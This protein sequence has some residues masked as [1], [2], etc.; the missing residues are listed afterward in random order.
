M[1]LFPVDPLRLIAAIYRVAPDKQVHVERLVERIFKFERL[2]FVSAHLDA[3]EI[4]ESSF[5]ELW[6]LDIGFY[7]D[8]DTANYVCVD[9]HDSAN[10]LN[11]PLNPI[12][13]NPSWMIQRRMA[14]IASP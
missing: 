4:Y 8:L 6:S 12:T 10:I 14:L 3:I 1:L 11:N 9:G 13:I 2:S 5:G 7:G